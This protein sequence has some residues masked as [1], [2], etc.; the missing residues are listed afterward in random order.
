MNEQQFREKLLEDSALLGAWGRLVS[1]TIHDELEKELGGSEKIKALL[2]IPV[3]PRLK[4]IDSAI[5]KAFIRKKY[6]DP[7]NQMTD[8][9]G[10][11]FVTLLTDDVRLVESV[12]NRISIW[13]ARK[14]RDPEE[15]AAQKPESFE[16][17]SLH[18]VVTNNKP[19]TFEKQKIPKGTTCEIQIR[20]MLQHVYSELTHKLIYKSKGLEASPDARRYVA[21]SMALLETTDEILV[22]V[23][24]KAPD[25]IRPHEAIAARL[26]DIYRT[27]TGLMPVVGTQTE[28]AIIDAFQDRILENIDEIAAACTPTSTIA[29]SI[30]DNASDHTFFRLPVITAIYYLVKKFPSHVENNWPLGSR[31]KYLSMVFTDMGISRD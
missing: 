5:E 26:A 24:K 6:P 27:A 31:E 8:K 1:K 18:Y 15:E 16:Y 10:V 9:V 28:D 19:R 21:R 7:Y 20:S 13:S 22:Q 12:I 23:H 29:G 25:V 30:Q 4:E 14:D 2:K 3:E 17:Q 11:R